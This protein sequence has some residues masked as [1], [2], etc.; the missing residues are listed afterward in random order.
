MINFLKLVYLQ[1]DG[2]IA[3]LPPELKNLYGQLF[4]VINNSNINQQVFDQVVDTIKSQVTD[5][6]KY[7]KIMFRFLEA[8]QASLAFQ[9]LSTNI[10]KITTLGEIEQAQLDLNKLPAYVRT[11]EDGLELQKK[12]EEKRRTTHEGSFE[13]FLVNERGYKAVYSEERLQQIN[14]V[15]RQIWKREGKTDD[16]PQIELGDSEQ[17]AIDIVKEIKRGT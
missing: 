1:R 4:S 9:Q 8:V 13:S 12:L 3:P 2:L 15:I 14:S 17:K 6:I 10:E 5:P 16:P 11:T 7:E